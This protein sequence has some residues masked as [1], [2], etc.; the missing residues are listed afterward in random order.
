MSLDTPL[1][2]ASLSLTAAV[3]WG[4][5]DFTGGLAS[6]R[7][8]ALRTVLISYSVGLTMLLI[9]ALASAEPIPP[10][11]DL[12]WGALAG[13][14]GMI[15]VGFLYQGFSKGRMGIVAPL[16]A[17]LATA[18]PVIFSV[19]TAR[20]PNVLQVVGF[21]VA[22]VG[23]W[24]LNRSGRESSRPIELGMATIAG[25][26]FGIFFIAL[27]QVGKDTVF[28]PLIAGRSAACTMIIIFALVTH[29]PLLRQS[30]L[31]LL[32]LAGTLDV[33][34]NLFF[35]LATQ[36]GRLDIVSVLGSLYPA[37][38]TLLAQWMLK[39]HLSRPQLIGIS[40]AMLAIILITI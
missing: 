17:V 11:A 7:S 10:M 22:L 24:L 31:R 4:A 1:L 13:I 3:C 38:T 33:G 25:L 12:G 16:S 32:F 30:P 15:G 20:L 27:D 19:F 14:C 2:A 6:R 35:L 5:G 23:I 34:G 37:V 28:W 8:S 26:G 40:A 39:E 36:K 21:G 18:L 29:R 9:V